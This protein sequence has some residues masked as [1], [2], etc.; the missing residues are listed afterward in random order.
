M[1]SGAA[2]LVLF[3]L[4]QRG[5]G[6][7]STLIL[8]R[9]LVPA[10][11][12]LVAMGTSIFAVLEVMSTFSFDLALIQ[13]QA[14]ERRHYDTAWTF[15]VLFGIVNGATMALL[16]HPAALFFDEP[17]VEAIMY[18][19]AVCALISGFDNIGV[20]AF[21]KD[22]ELHKEFRLGMAKKVTAFVVTVSVAYAVRNYWALIVGMLAGRIASSVLTY[23]MH[24]YRPRLSLAAARE[25]FHFSKWLLINNLLVFVNNRGVDLVI[26]KIAGPRALGLYSVSY[27]ISNLPTTELVFPISRAVFPGFSKLA[28]NKPALRATFLEV[29]ALI[30]M[31][32]LPAGVGIALVAEPMVAVLLGAKW[33]ETVSLIQVLAAFGILRALH[34]PTGSIYLA[35][36]KPR[37]ISA[38][39]TVQ[40]LVAAPLLVLLT[41][42][43]G[44]AGAPWAILAGIAFAMPINYAWV[45]RELGLSLRMFAHAFWR[46]VGAAAA[47]FWT[48]TWIR[49]AWLAPAGID[50]GL[51]ALVIT[52]AAGAIIYVLCVVTLWRLARCP[53]GAESRL[54]GL[55]KMRFFRAA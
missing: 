26:A 54:F 6:F 38:L 34:G 55:L 45:A 2:W 27:E 5:L 17:R 50:H 40:I 43:F 41:A 44:I 33:T 53:Q 52:I 39:Q 21:Q 30:A 46:P 48:C 42:R 49:E 51:P 9:L 15:N 47:M 20:V 8:A 32:A 23:A 16:A 12:G 19:L 35:L 37:I 4:L 1:A 13:N 10:D 7:I 31:V 36:G 25:L 18:A 28:A 3:T 11:F 29:M 14:T 22:L 24:P